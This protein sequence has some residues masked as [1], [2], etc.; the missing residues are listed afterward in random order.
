MLTCRLFCITRQNF[1]W[2]L[3]WL[4]WGKYY[5]NNVSMIAL[6]TKT[7]VSRWMGFY[8]K[9]NPKLS[10]EWIKS[11]LQDQFN[12]V[13]CAKKSLTWKMFSRTIF[14]LIWSDS[15]GKTLVDSQT[16]SNLRPWL[17]LCVWNL[18]LKSIFNS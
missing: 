13:C 10:I 4:L 6:A 14:C 3:G 2:I 15:G 16:N 8:Y 1:W 11:R 9:Y 17:D 7:N 18:S 12:S 5:S